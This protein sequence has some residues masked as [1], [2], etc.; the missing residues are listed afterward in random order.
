MHV[1][2]PDMKKLWKSHKATNNH[3]IGGWGESQTRE[4]QTNRNTQS[5]SIRH[6][7]Q[8]PRNIDHHHGVCT[9]PYWPRWVHYPPSL[10]ILSFPFLSFPTLLKEGR[11]KGD[12]CGLGF[13]T[14]VYMYV[15]IY[16][17]RFFFIHQAMYRGCCCWSSSSN[18]PNSS[19]KQPNQ[20]HHQP[21][22][23][24]HHKHQKN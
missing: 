7:S 1:H 2:K 17:S 5:L 24:S 12:L 13:P 10:L 14:Y 9:I 20:P 23:M 15:R 18:G 22:H 3:K 11:R 4:N 19:H 16:L 6:P 21:V 8:A